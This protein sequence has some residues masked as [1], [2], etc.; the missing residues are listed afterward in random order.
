[1]KAKKQAA[2]CME[3]IDEAGHPKSLSKQEWVELLEIIISDCGS[4]LE[5]AREE[6]ADEGR[7]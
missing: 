4:R 6:M 5:A 3:F 2:R 7:A 1:M